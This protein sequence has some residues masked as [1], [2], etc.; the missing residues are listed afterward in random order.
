MEI[1]SVDAGFVCLG[2]GWGVDTWNLGCFVGFYFAGEGK[3]RSR[4]P[5]G[6]TERKAKARAT[7]NTG[8]LRS[9]QDDGEKRATTTAKARARARAKAKAKAN[10]GI[11][12]CALG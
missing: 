10:T 1:A 4:F 5:E 7:A 8:V 9:A 12:R 6:M 2:G 11:L 3:G